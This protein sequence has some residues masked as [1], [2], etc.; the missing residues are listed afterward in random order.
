M[1]TT[2]QQAPEVIAQLIPKIAQLTTEQPTTAELEEALL[3][4][5]A[6]TRAIFEWLASRYSAQAAARQGYEAPAGQGGLGLAHVHPAFTPVLNNLM[7][8]PA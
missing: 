2:E 4:T 7:R 1:R 8:R 3:T 6:L 5:K